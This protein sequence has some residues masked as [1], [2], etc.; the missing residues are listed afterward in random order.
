VNVYPITLTTNNL[1]Y[2]GDIGGYSY[3]S[4]AYSFSV[5][6][7]REEDGRFFYPSDPLQSDD[8]AIRNLSAQ[9][10][11]GKTGDREWLQA[12]HDRVVSALYYDDASLDP[13]ARKKQD[14]LS[15]LANRTAVCEGYTSLFGALARAAGFQV[16]AAS[17]IAN[18]GNHAWNLVLTGSAWPMVDCTWDDPGPNDADPSQVAY[19]YFLSPGPNGDQGDH[20]WQDDRPSRDLG[21][22]APP[23]AGISA[24]F[25][26]YPP[27][28][29]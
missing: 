28:C 12:L 4:A 11:L 15:V 17:G 1:D 16:K 20:A 9:L 7:T 25:G 3:S 18:G 13:G 6:N 2:E 8:L 23:A 14:A 19:S 26:S 27:G 21:S 10:V 29:Y 5:A 24:G 22:G